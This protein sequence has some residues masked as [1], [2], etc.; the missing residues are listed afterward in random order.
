MSE[1]KPGEMANLLIG[2]LADYQPI[3]D[4]ADG[5]R[6]Q[7]EQRGWSPTAAEA[8]SLTW[9]QGAMAQTWKAAT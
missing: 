5:M 4:A 9:L 8:V 6:A 1:P 7:L 3:F 2:M